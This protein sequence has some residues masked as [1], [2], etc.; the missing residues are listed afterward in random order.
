MTST[1]GHLIGRW[2]VVAERPLLVD[3]VLALVLSAAVFKAALPESTHRPTGWDVLIAVVAF[4]AVLGRR[5]RPLLAL[6]IAT[7][8]TA[9]AVVQ[10]VRNP[11]LIVALGVITYSIAAHTD[12]R[13]GWACAVA[14]S[15]VVYLTV[16]VLNRDAWLRADVLGLFAWVF[17]AAAVGDA[18][19]SHRAY[20]REVEE[21]AHRAEQSREDEARR[22]VTE[23]RL[24]IARELHD[25]VA[26]HI[27]VINV[28][29]G[30]AA[31]VMARRPDQV[32]PALAHIRDASDSV[33]AEIQSV[34]GVL[35]ADEPGGT[36]T[37]TEPTPGLARLPELLD[38][39]AAAGLAVDVRRDGEPGELPAVVD[40]AAYRIAQEALTNAHKHGAGATRLTVRRTAEAVEIEVLNAMPP[41]APPA[42]SGYGLLGMRE[43]A[44]TAGGTLTAGV[45]SD[46]FRVH[47]VLPAAEPAPAPAG[48]GPR[49][50]RLGRELRDAMVSQIA[51]VNAQALAAARVLEEPDRLREASDSVLAQARSLAGR[52][53]DRLPQLVARL[54][55]A[56][57]T[58]ELR[59][60]GD[61]SPVPEAACRIAEEALTGAHRHGVRAARLTV[62]QRPGA[63][64]IEVVGTTGDEFRMHAVLPAPTPTPARTAGR[65]AR[66]RGRVRP[67]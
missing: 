4:V 33:L 26:H 54:A 55:R 37:G 49:P 3:F 66:P 59:Q 17:L 7:T 16:V 31:H 52:P 35:R 38:G 18:T 39:L 53:G 57:L 6:A 44:V 61:Q 9:A 29:A 58:V 8:A 13:R 15:T 46:G 60:R 63:V 41:G 12:R 48:C 40:L 10:E 28:Q 32:A 2:R 21:R 27:A 24:R 23:E 43:R 45:T 65:G 14:A 47:A 64:E 22:R 50:L 19:R 30:A 25:V 62:D 56:G 36:P 42:G 51:A 34:V 11:G 5:R 1:E 20:V 67:A